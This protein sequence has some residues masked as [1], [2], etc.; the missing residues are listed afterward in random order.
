MGTV[1]LIHFQKPYKHA[2]HYLGY[3]SNLDDRLDAHRKGNGAR[4]MEVVGNEGIDWVLARTWKGG[5][6]LERKLKNQKN[7]PRLCP[8][9]R[10]EC[11]E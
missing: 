9:C 8:I 11:S 1:Y 2:K 5:R 6:G 10:K 3:S 4:L 7:S